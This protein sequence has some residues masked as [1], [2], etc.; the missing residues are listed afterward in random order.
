MTASVRRLR[1][2]RRLREVRL[3]VAQR[4]LGACTRQLARSE[5]IWERLSALRAAD[6]TPVQTVDVAALAMRADAR[7]RLDTAMTHIDRSRG[8]A[9]A[10]VDHAMQAMHRAKARFEVVSDSYDLARRRE[11]ARGEDR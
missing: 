2:L 10:A 3:T 7:D 5:Q 9:K 6:A 11:I 4:D 8:A 1:L